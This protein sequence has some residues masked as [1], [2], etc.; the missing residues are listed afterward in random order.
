MNRIE[1]IRKDRGEGGREGG[2]GEKG[3]KEEKGEGGRVLGM[4][5]KRIQLFRK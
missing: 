3:E 4:N 1:A 2:R 5:K